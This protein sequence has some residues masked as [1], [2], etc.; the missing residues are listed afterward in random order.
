MLSLSYTFHSRMLH[1][2][3]SIY[4]Q[5]GEVKAAHLHQP[6]PILEQAYRVSAVHATLAIEGN[7]LEARPVADLM[8]ERPHVPEPTAIEVTNTQRVLDL[9]PQW[10]PF[11]AQD[12]RQA[13][14]ELMRGLAMDAGSYRTGPVDVLYGDHHAPRPATAENI[15][16]QMED[17]LDF[18]END[19]TPPIITSCVLHYGIASLRPFT[20]GNGRMARLWQKRMLMKF[21]P[22]FSY[23]PIEGFILRTEPAYHAALEYADR[24][25][26]CGGFIT[27]LLE[28][29]EEALAEVLTAQR[30]VFSGPE[31]VRVYLNE[32][33]PMH[34]S[35]QDYRRSFP[36]LSTAT[37]S[38][39]LAE[40]VAEGAIM[41]T[42]KGRTAWYRPNG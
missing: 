13:H 21:W 20:A 3:T 35:R 40:A 38:R 1:L 27:Y 6:S 15:P 16:S 33:K 5:L 32:K 25:G 31:R 18:A 37:A 42:G 14:G 12:L 9:L 7:P 39:D 22:V 17:L 4:H 11:V 28:R 29:I 26:D 30:P 2:L 41:L 36:E 19:D 24:Q 23:L 10:D 34:F 8:T